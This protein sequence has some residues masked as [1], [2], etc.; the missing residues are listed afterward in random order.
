MQTLNNY[1]A[2]M[3]VML[4]VHHVLILKTRGWILYSRNFQVLSLKN[5]LRTETLVLSFKL[6]QY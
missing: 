3:L 1:T 5:I 6:N 4:I 2:Q